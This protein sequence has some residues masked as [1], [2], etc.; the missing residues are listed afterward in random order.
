MANQVVAVTSSRLNDR[1]TSELYDYLSQGYEVRMAIS[2]D[3]YVEYI[4]DPPVAE[5]T[6][7]VRKEFKVIALDDLEDAPPIME[8]LLNVGWSMGY[9]TEKLFFFER[10]VQ[11][12]EGTDG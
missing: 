7:N 3:D 5:V 2:V 4:L 6:A 10:V 8:K 1:D 11:D 12:K 9:S